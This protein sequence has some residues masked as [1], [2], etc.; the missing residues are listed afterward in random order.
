MRGAPTASDVERF[1]RGIVDR[2][3][4]AFDDDRLGF[5]AGILSKLVVSA[6]LSA[7]RFLEALE[8]GAPPGGLGPLAEALTVGE[9]YFFRNTDQQRALL[10]TILPDRIARRASEK[11]LSLLSAACSSGEEAYSLAILLK[12]LGVGPSWDVSIRAVD[13]NPAV[14]SRARAG[15]YS[16][17]SFRETSPER[18]SRWF[19]PQGQ[20]FL[21]DGSIRAAVRF[22]QRN[23]AAEDEDLWR[24]ESYDVVLCRNAIM[25]FS[26]PQAAAVL[27][28]I[29]RALVPGG[30]LLLGHAESL[31][32][33][34]SGFELCNTHDTFYYRRTG[35]PWRPSLSRAK[36]EAAP[37]ADPQE[38]DGRWVAVIGEAAARIRAL[39]E[40]P[41]PASTASPRSPS[42]VPAWDLA[43]ALGLLADERF[44]EARAMV[45][46]LPPESALDPDVLLLRS[47]L[48]MHA[49]ET[50]AA[51]ETCGKLLEV[52][53]MSVGARYVLALCREAR[54]DLVS[55]AEHDRIAIRIDP[56]FSLP[57]LHLGLLSRRS[58]DV[59]T[60]AEE[61]ARAL[62]LLASEDPSRILLFGGGFKREVLVK[63]CRAELARC[64]GLS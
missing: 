52:D 54:G 42:P 16:Q 4:L 57:R 47:V 15:N 12:E 36:P 50:A 9:T 56:S 6:G 60:A 21:I 64:R 7:E 18:R 23:L 14:L 19:A 37:A 8:H 26:P 34:S 59:A 30:Y 44:P 29:A 1:R 31:H 27:E 55:A 5:L 3:G 40:A 53:E 58:G 45:D 2:L 24:P 38:A 61:L 39:A 48:L 41:L 35:A 49:G 25:Y 51:E 13:V 32:G 46:T 20:G 33:V 10:E 11:R 17:W 62:P 63:L 43:P 28:R 22:E